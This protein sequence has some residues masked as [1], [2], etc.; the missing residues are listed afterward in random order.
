MSHCLSEVC[1]KGLQSIEEDHHI[2]ELNIHD[3]SK[4][5]NSVCVLGTIQFMKLFGGT[6]CKSEA[7]AIFC[8]I[9][10]LLHL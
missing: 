4:F 1:V 5:E 7:R 2:T 3:A 10:Q 9:P 6:Y 8:I